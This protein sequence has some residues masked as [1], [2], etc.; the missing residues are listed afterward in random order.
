MKRLQHIQANFQDYVLG[1]G[2]IAPELGAAVRQQAGLAIYHNAYRVRMREALNEAYERT[3]TYVG[4]DLFGELT[5]G[6]LAEYG[7]TFTNL[8]WF[9]H[10]YADFVRQQ[11]PDYPFIAELAAF[12]WALGLA[13]DAREAEVAGA[14]AFR[15]LAPEA[16][17]S[18]ELTLQPSVQLLRMDYNSVALWQAL[19]EG[20]EPP[21]AQA[22]GEQCTWLVWRK[23]NQ[24]HFRSLDTFEAA[25]L[26]AV[27]AG[28]T[29]GEI[30]EQAGPE[31]AL[32]MGA[33]LQNWMTQS[34]L[35]QIGIE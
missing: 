3:W 12:E 4:D 21:L 26:H 1:D 9:G 31:N 14:D 33:C 28:S 30:C 2:A 19:G 16:W 10:R 32:R 35:A 23:D 8:R 5:D 18:L 24:P 29:F 13:F 11:L 20:L 34:M 27:A 17:A 25:A 15:H 22:L 7:S 6:Y